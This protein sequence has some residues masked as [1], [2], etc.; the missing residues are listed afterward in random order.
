MYSTCV[1]CHAALGHN[2]DVEEFPVGRRLAFDSTRGRLWVVCSACLRWNLTPIEERWEAIETCERLYEGTRQRFSTDQIGLGRLPS[3]LDLIRVGRPLRPEFAAWRY[4]DRF[5]QRRR[6]FLLRSVAGTAFTSAGAVAAQL[7][8][9]AAPVILGGVALIALRHHYLEMRS[10]QVVA[11]VAGTA[12]DEL[13]VTRGDLLRVDFAREAEDRWALDLPNPLGRVRLVDGA[14][15][16]VGAL[17]MAEM[18][19]AGASADQLN[20]AIRKLEW[21]EGPE[22]LRRFAV[23]KG[24]LGKLGYE[25]RLAIEMALHE[26]SERRALEGELAD[27]E[28]MWREAEELASIADNLLLPA[29]VTDWIDRYLRGRGRQAGDSPGAG[30]EA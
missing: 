17:A 12:G 25:Q 29:S 22:G 7:P 2:D 4:G 23:R 20:Q 16:H 11:R 6:R 18:N 14:A 27:L 26:E 15:L 1:H 8:I 13:A 3:G 30:R 21:F 19:V 28:R 24:G 5:G 10:E 9:V